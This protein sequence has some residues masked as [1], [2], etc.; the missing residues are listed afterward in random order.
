MNICIAD[1]VKTGLSACLVWCIAVPSLAGG[2]TVWSVPTAEAEKTNPVRYDVASVTI[3]KQLFAEHCQTCHGYWGEGNGIVGLT[4]N[5]QPANLLRI[6]G[7]QSAGAFA[8]KIATGRNVM[9][10][11][12]GTLTEEQIWHVVNF[13]TSLENEIGSEGQAPVVRRCAACHGL[14]GRAVYREWPDISGMSQE[15][16]E[17]KLYAHRSGGD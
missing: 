4:L 17:R 15:E 14:E 13:I 11:F 12:R 1:C 8:W 6:A 9:P 2:D 10:T 5:N 16:I 3:G 7:K